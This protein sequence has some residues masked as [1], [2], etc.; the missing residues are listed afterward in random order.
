M[1]EVIQYPYSKQYS[2][3]L[4]LYRKSFFKGRFSIFYKIY[5]EENIIWI[6]HFRSNKQKPLFLI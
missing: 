3:I 1:L 2:E 6:T 5:E 4:D